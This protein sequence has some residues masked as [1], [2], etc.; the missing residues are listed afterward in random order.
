M[1]A[2]D[3]VLLEDNLIFGSR[4]R[5][6]LKG[7]PLRSVYRLDSLVA[8]AQQ[9]AATTVILD[10][11]GGAPDRLAAVRALRATTRARIIGIAGHKERAVRAAAAQAGCHAVLP[12]SAVPVRLQGV[13]AGEPGS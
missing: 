3:V 10:L 12:H 13:I 2:P 11:S 9:A 1:D 8:A 6:A 5:A 7:V 4:I